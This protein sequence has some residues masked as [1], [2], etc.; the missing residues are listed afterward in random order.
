MLRTDQKFPDWVSILIFLCLVIFG[1]INI[2]SA[3]LGEYGTYHGFDFNEIY[4]KQGVWIGMSLVLVVLVLS[5]EARFYQRFASLIYLSSLLLLVG[6][7][8]FGTAISG[9]RAWYSFGSF[10]IQPAEFVKATTALALAKYLSDIQTNIKSLKHQTNAFLIIFIPAVLI[11]GQPDPGS[12]LIYSAFIFPLYR[13]GLSG[14]YLFLGFS[15]VTL[16][17]LTLVFGPVWVSVGVFILIGSI[18][19]LSKRQ[20]HTLRYI[21][22]GA[23]CI[24]FT[25]SVDYIFNNVFQQHHRDRFNVV[26]G[27][28]SD[29]Q[30]IGYN[31]NQSIITIGSGGWWGKGWAQGTQTKGNFVPEQHTDY[32]FSTVGEEWGFMGSAFVVLLFVGLISRVLF[33][34]E[35]QKTKFARVYGYS[36][37]GILFIHFSINIGMVIGI[38]PTVGVPLPFLSYG[39]SSL[40]GFT[41]LLFMFLKLDAD[42]KLASHF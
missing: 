33:L 4:T 22:I 29:T 2:Y 25:F 32:I 16:F 40:W 13:E 18:L 24:L 35:R 30:G 41:I 19:F 12:A 28:I 37:A 15:S 26:L 6:L 39:G 7:F 5:V 31:T 21:G 17:V 1:W 11:M 36:V 23:F 8:F 14:G 34:A 42:R 10:S 3:S 9:Q 27:H 38:L 20:K